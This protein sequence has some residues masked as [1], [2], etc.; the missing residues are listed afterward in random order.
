MADSWKDE[1][2]NGKAWRH[3]QGETPWW[4]RG[5]GYWDGHFKHQ[6][7]RGWALHCQPFNGGYGHYGPP[8]MRHHEDYF[9]E[10]WKAQREHERESYKARL[11]WE[12]E[13]AKLYREHRG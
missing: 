2:G 8:P 9:K 12:R 13:R 7:R 5:K 3:S 1:S 4:A 6:K 10:L 11:E